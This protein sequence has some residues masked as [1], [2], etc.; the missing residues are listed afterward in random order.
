MIKCM[1]GTQDALTLATKEPNTPIPERG[2]DMTSEPPKEPTA[3]SP[4]A[5]FVDNGI[6]FRVAAT[7]LG[8]AAI[9]GTLGSEA[10]GGPLGSLDGPFAALV[11][12][13]VGALSA[14]PWQFPRFL[15]NDV[16]GTTGRTDANCRCNLRRDLLWPRLHSPQD[17]G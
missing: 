14:W 4:V 13:V 15:K 3:T 5:R 6:P 9:G 10:V 2:D 7:T 17:L 12:A 16:P 11:G 8:S 1:S